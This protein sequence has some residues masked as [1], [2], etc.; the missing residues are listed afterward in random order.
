MKNK[1][2][3]VFKF[4]SPERM[5]I[6]EKGLIR[7]TP[8]NDFNDPFELNPTITHHTIDW[9]QNHERERHDFDDEDY[10]FSSARYAEIGRYR[11]I[12]NEYAEAH[13]VLSLS[14]SEHSSPRLDLYMDYEKDPRK[15]LLLWS[16]YASRHS[17]MAIEFD[18]DFIDGEL[19]QVIYDKERPVCTFE[20]IEKQTHRIYLNKSPEW[21]YESEWRIFK[22]LAMADSTTTSN[23]HLFRIKKSA[24]KSVTFGCR[25]SEDVKKR[26]I[27]IL[28]SDSEYSHVQTFFASLDEA[29]F[30]LTFHMEVKVGDKN[31]SNAPEFQSR[32]F[33]IQKRPSSE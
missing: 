30:K 26:V 24:V 10:R 33:T 32:C 25:W 14:G 21:R 22:P 18:T 2:S 9:V 31:W 6:L 1:P 7:F 17:G 3:S 4:V 8:P 23:M 11:E 29:A 12:I 19:V 27:E 28:G 20:E 15:N 13:G 16:H 5:D